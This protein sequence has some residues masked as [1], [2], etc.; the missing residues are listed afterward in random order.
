[1]KIDNTPLFR[2]FRLGNLVSDRI[3]DIMKTILGKTTKEDQRIAKSSLDKAQKAAKKIQSAKGRAVPIKLQNAKDAL[4]IPKK[5]LLMLFEIVGNMAD[6]KSM[7]IIESEDYLTTQQA[8]VIL[9]VSRPFVVGLLEKGKIPYKKVGAHRRIHRKHVEAY[10]KKQKKI[11][12][13]ALTFLV[14]QAQELKMGYE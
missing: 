12:E 5:A 3:T 14:R 6:G 7:T 9:N 2:L 1:M 10:E 4:L 13:K 8:A 11:R